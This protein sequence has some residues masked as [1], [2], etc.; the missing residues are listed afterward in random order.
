VDAF[1]PWLE[2]RLR[3]HLGTERGA[4]EIIVA[5][6]IVFLFWLLLTGRRV[7]VQ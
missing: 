1:L 4:S 3:A 7:V 5:V 2:M 6:L